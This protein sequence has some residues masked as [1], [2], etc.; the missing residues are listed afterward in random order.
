LIVGLGAGTGSFV[1]VIDG[2]NAGILLDTF[3]PFGNGVTTGISVGTVD[4][5]AD[6]SAEV[7]VGNGR[8]ASRLI[9]V[10]DGTTHTLVRTISDPASGATVGD[11]V[12]GQV[13]RLT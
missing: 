1:E 3:S 9:R 4:V 2:A 12:A 5:N 6:G 13:F 8:G 7:M 11:F 10:Y